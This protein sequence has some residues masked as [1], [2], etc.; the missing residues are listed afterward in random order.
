MWIPEQ[1]RTPVP[2]DKG[3]PVF[4]DITV[5]NLV[6]K[7]CGSVG[8]IIGLDNSP[9]VNMKLENVTIENAEKGLVV[10]NTRG[11]QCQKVTVNGKPWSGPSETQLGM[12]R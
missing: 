1:F 2:A 10:R 9:I 7:N 12:N 6:A 8:R 5:R 4:R 11:L 3:T